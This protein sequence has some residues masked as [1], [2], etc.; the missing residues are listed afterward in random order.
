MKTKTCLYCTCR[1][2]L[3]KLLPAADL[4]SALGETVGLIT[5]DCLCDAASC[6]ALAQPLKE[7]LPGGS[8]IAVAACSRLARG[9]DAL[10][11]A[12]DNFSGFRVGLA[13]IRE[14]CAWQQSD[15]AA[16]AAQ[17]AAAVDAA[18]AGLDRPPNEEAER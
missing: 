17:A 6:A 4:R 8:R 2:Q 1:G 5:A 7:A 14:G 16:R 11:S 13:D 10:R 3:E 18:Y 12:A 15:P 9:S